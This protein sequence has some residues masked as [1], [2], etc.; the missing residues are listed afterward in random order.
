MQSSAV[1]ESI[2]FMLLGMG[3]VYAFLIVMIYAIKLQAKIIGKYFPIENEGL[4]K[5]AASKSSTNM[6]K[7][8]AAIAATIYHIKEQK[9]E[10]DV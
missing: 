7:K 10:S 2:K 5:E 4:K 9:K 6:N 3:V 8:V 1:V